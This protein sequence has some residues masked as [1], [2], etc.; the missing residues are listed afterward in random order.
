MLEPASTGPRDAVKPRTGGALIGADLPVRAAAGAVMMTLASGA[1]W[2]GGIWF[3]IFWG[4]AAMAVA[5]EWTRLSRAGPLA[6]RDNAG[7]YLALPL[8]AIFL[9]GDVA[10][11]VSLLIAAGVCAAIVSGGPRLWTWTAAGVIYAGSMLISVC[12]LRASS[13][14]GLRVILWLFAVVWGTDIMAYFGGRLI[15]GPKL[16][17][18]VSPGKTWSGFFVGIVSGAAA[19]L[20]AAPESTR[21]WG[22]FAVGLVAAIASQ[23]GDLFESAIK[24]HFGVKDSGHLI[25]G[26]GGAMDRLDGFIAA[27]LVAAMIGAFR[28]GWGQMASGVLQW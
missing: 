20:L 23:G 12:L 2:A 26:H 27:A 4:A 7:L 6:L 14:Y 5:N 25:P 9:R 17:V 24:R 11:W 15:G 16:W 21:L 1:A 13:P 28:S 22:V 3:E 10:S 18:R 8:A 19:G